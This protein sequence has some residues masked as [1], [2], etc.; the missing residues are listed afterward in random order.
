FRMWGADAVGMS[1][2]PEVVVARHAGMRVMGVSSITNEAIDDQ[3]SVKD[4]SHE[5]VLA[6]GAK[7]VPNLITILRGVLREFPE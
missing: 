7:I 2:V 5:E 6:V 3:D 4:V 1:T